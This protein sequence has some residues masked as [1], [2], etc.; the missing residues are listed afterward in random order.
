MVQHGPLNMA[1]AGA[2]LVRRAWLGGIG[3]LASLRK[4][5]NGCSGSLGNGC[6]GS[7]GNG[8]ENCLATS[9][10]L[11]VGSVPMYGLALL[12]GLVVCLSAKTFAHVQHQSAQ[13]FAHVQHQS[14]QTFAHVQHHSAQTAALGFAPRSDLHQ[15]G[16]S[17][18]PLANLSTSI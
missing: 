17:A 9:L 15:A 3:R 13:T 12:H 6:S 14:A 5:G 1:L 11:A 2:T 8:L 4:P 18:F 10:M 7:L 16:H